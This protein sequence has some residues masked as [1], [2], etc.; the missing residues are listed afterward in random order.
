MTPVLGQM[1]SVSLEMPKPG[2]HSPREVGEL[3][4]GAEATEPMVVEESREAPARCAARCDRRG[5][6]RR[7][8]G[9]GRRVAKKKSKETLLFSLSG[10]MLMRDKS[11]RDQR[12]LHLAA[13]PIRDRPP[14]PTR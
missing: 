9:D 4:V 6:G 5:D 11:P 10:G 3:V 12:T 7:A 2:D 14:A 8:T 13:E 1:E